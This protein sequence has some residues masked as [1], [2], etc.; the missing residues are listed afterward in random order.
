[1]SLF[2]ANDDSSGVGREVDDSALEK[3][4]DFCNATTSNID[5]EAGVGMRK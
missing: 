2:P 4:A 5:P 1:M 3:S